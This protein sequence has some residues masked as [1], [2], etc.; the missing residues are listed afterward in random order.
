V[1][2]TPSGFSGLSVGADT[3]SSEASLIGLSAL[4]V[5]SFFALDNSTLR[6]LNRPV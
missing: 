2:V 3:Q 5:D 4:E 1:T 6:K